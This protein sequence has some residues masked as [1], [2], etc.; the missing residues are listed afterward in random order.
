MQIILKDENE[1]NNSGR[2][3]PIGVVI[4]TRRISRCMEGKFVGGFRKQ[5]KQNVM[6]TTRH[7]VQ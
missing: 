1:R 2:T 4:Y 5:K 7:K 6:A 3:N